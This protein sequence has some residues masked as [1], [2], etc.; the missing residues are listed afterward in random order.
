M[1]N[2]IYYPTE[3]EFQQFLAETTTEQETMLICA[4]YVEQVQEDMPAGDELE[5][6]L[7]KLGIHLQAI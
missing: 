5:A 4:E 3:A 2:T 1:E 6:Q 7:L